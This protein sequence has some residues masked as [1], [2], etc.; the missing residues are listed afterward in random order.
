MSSTVS[1]P[2]GTK[3]KINSKNEFELCYIRHRYFRK[4]TKNPSDAEMAPYYPIVKKLSQKTYFTYKHLFDIIGFDL[5]DV[6][7]I[8]RI[9]IVNYV[10]LFS[11]EVMPEKMQA[12]YRSFMIAKGDEPETKDYLDKNK[13]NFTM[14]LKQRM[15]DVVRICRQKARN[16]K[17]INVDTF[18]LYMGQKTPPKDILELL[19][20]HEELGFRK[21]DPMS[22]RTAKKRSNSR[23]NVFKHDGLWYV[24]IPLEHKN[25]NITDFAGADMDPYDN[26]HN[27]TPEK[28]VSDQHESEFWAQKAEAFKNTPENEKSKIVRAFIAKHKDDPSYEDEIKTARK[29]L[30]RI[31]K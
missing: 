29:L 13:A 18:A 21:I 28:L 17:G 9:H 31:G 20:V 24:A 26:L 12:F 1:R 16:V 27:M 19:E 25:L 7:A 3:T 2:E 15:E 14:F 6:I 22:F 5:D 30:K 11:L 4:T 23:D 8:G 10:G